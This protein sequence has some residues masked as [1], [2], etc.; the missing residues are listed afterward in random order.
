MPAAGAALNLARGASRAGGGFALG[1]GPL[2]APPAAAPGAEAARP[3]PLIACAD[4]GSVVPGGGAIINLTRGKARPELA[5]LWP[6]L[7]M[8]SPTAEASAHDE[9]AAESSAAAGEVVGCTPACVNSP[10]TCAAGAAGAA[11]WPA[12]AA[13]CTSR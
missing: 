10:S 7:A 4:G 3:P 12:A 9:A 8:L 6:K 11:T 1:K 13:A 2:G 5:T